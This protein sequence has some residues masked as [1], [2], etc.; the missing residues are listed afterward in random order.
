MQIWSISRY[1]PLFLY[2]DFRK[3]L[4]KSA[5]CSRQFNFMPLWLCNHRETKYLIQIDLWSS[6]ILRRPHQIMYRWR[7][8]QQFAVF[9]EYLNIVRNTCT[10]LSIGSIITNTISSL[11][12]TSTS[13]GGDTIILAFYSWKS[14]SG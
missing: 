5:I 2:F 10:V 8:P 7:L 11:C 6:D 14:I 13:P 3:V 9:S 12:V 4:L 1:F